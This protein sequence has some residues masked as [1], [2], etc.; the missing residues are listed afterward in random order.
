MN[1]FP[2]CNEESYSGKAQVQY[3]IR[4]SV[5]EDTGSYRNAYEF[6]IGTDKAGK[7]FIYTLAGYAFIDKTTYDELLILCKKMY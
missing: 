6:F 7:E 1:Q 2:S 5:L 4:L 3:Y